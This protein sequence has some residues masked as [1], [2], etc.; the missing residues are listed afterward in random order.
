[1]GI[2]INKRKLGAE[3]EE[4]AVNYLLNRG[5]VILE[6]NY[7]CKFGEIDIIARQKTGNDIFLIFIEVKYRKNLR[8]GNP[9]EAVNI[10]KQR[11]IKKVAEY[12]LLTKG[13]SFSENIRFDVVGI[14]GNKIEL[15]QN[16][17]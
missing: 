8:K 6:R 5:Y 17:F 2:N 1:M 13:Y 10:Q 15:I 11:I 4:L 3:Y 16:A 14:T 7:R 9:F 12:Y